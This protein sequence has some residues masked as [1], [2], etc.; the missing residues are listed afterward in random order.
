[1]KEKK[2]KKVHVNIYMFVTTRSMSGQSFD[3]LLRVRPEVQ[4]AVIRI[5][6]IRNSAGDL[7]ESP[8]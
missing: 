5:F 6:Q 4:S 3:Y 1:M 8:T 2:K 7:E